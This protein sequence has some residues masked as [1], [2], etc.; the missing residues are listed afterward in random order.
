MTNF[1]AMLRAMAAS[2]WAEK[3]E[4]DAEL[5]A[6]ADELERLQAFEAGFGPPGE[7]VSVNSAT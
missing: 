5:N 6:A 1:V 4:H 3:Y 7:P 2:T